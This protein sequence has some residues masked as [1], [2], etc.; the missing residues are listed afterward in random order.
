M[1]KF[2]KSQKIAMIFSVL[3]GI[4]ATALL[5]V[6]SPTF[7]ITFTETKPTIQEYNVLKDYALKVASG[8]EVVEE[9]I[10]EKK[11]EKDFL[12]IKIEV[13]NIYGVESYFPISV[14]NNLKIQNGKVICEAEI[15]Y[16]NATYSEYTFVK[17]KIGLIVADLI[18]ILAFL[19]VPYIVLY[20]G[21]KE[22]KKMKK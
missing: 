10:V 11:L 13:P 17:S 12:R 18:L 19:F 20:W 14:E 4:I 1:K 2:E 7:K 22:L 3:I 21:P 9:V 5:N 8:E 6:N 16:N 15:D